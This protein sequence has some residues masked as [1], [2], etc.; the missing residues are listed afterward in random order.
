M[1]GRA[2]A[3]AI[4][5]AGAVATAAVGYSRGSLTDTAALIVLIA[6]ASLGP[7]AWRGARG[8]L[9][10]FEP[11]TFVGL[12]CAL[13]FVARP[14]YESTVL[15]YQYIRR[16]LEPDYDSALI[17]AL[18]AIACFQLGY[19]AIRR[20][21]W[22]RSLP[23][24]REPRNARAP[25]VLAVVLTVIAGACVVVFG[26][27]RGKILDDRGAGFVVTTPFIA[28]ATLLALPAVLLLLAVARARGRRVSPLVLAPMIVLALIAIPAGNRR[29][30]LPV[31]LGLFTWAYLVRDRRP[32]SLTLAVAVVVLA[33]TVIGPLR[34]FRDGDQSLPAAAAHSITHPYSA[35]EEILRSQDTSP[36]SNIAL[37][38]AVMGDA[39]PYRHGRESLTSLLLAPVPT[40]L[41]P[42]KPAKARTILTDHYFGTTPSGGC[43]SQCPVYSLVGDLY[44]DAGLWSIGLGTLLLGCLFGALGAYLL[45]WRRN[46][47]AL[48]ALST[49]GWTA[50]Y[51]WWSGL[52]MVTVLLVMLQLPALAGAWLAAGP[53]SDQL[54]AGLRAP[55][56]GV[57]RR[58]WIAVAGLALASALATV[59]FL[60]PDAGGPARYG[61]V[62]TAEGGTALR[63]GS[64]ALV[65]LVPD[66]FQG[67]VEAASETPRGVQVSGWA[68][69][70]RSREPA[71]HIVVFM[72]ERFLADAGRTDRPDVRRSLRAPWIP[73]A[74]F[75][76]T[77]PPGRIQRDRP[78]LGVR[79]FA[80]GG[81][82]ATELPFLVARGLEREGG[83][84]RIGYPG[85]PMVKVT[86]AA[87]TGRVER[88]ALR[89]GRL[90]LRGWAVAEGSHEPVD[91]VLV[92]SGDRLLLET[93]PWR[94]RR[95]VVRRTGASAGLRSGFMADVPARGVTRRTAARIRVFGVADDRASE[96]PR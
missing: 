20:L 6:V 88:I 63:D 96:L 95:D 71:E 18:V 50:F 32:R 28:Q 44:A 79:V 34:D 77:A 51:P 46:P 22:H 37:E 38:T 13:L 59:L 64:G 5:C 48:A 81:G 7:L 74:G 90:L 75:A 87:A 45:R 21:G 83:A 16:D 70:V 23:P 2:T 29:Y 49:L 8:T 66:A 25:T 1:R 85:G 86:D 54:R 30:A 10:V 15:D 43:V 80:I 92:Y 40:E 69:G 52:S 94:D 56:R 65:P 78:H 62:S 14:A 55:W 12:G 60:L 19:H 4:V 33:I 39:V 11:V 17:A 76:A 35:F 24:L 61:L 26:V 42:G 84:L 3:V 57:R 68:T 41:W 89:D 58:P 27:E 53:R 82:R 31:V 47:Y 67:Y 91:R 93:W 36:I 73:H 72:G 9:D